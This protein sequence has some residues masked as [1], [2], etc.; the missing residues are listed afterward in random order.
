MRARGGKRG[1]GT[2]QASAVPSFVPPPAKPGI[3]REVQWGPK[4]VAKP[5][6]TVSSG[7]RN[8]ASPARTTGNGPLTTPP[9]SSSTG[10]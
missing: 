1:G 6:G 2:K 10:R 9:R 7:K 5:P 4:P 3:F 8:P